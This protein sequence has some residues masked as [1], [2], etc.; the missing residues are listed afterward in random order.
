MA[1][2]ELTRN[3]SALSVFPGI[4][5]CGIHVRFDTLRIAC[6]AERSRGGVRASEVRVIGMDEYALR[7]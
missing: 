1:E 7:L 3:V 2:E 4:L 6:E 5:V